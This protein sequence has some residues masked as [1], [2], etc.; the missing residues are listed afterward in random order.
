MGGL[1]LPENLQIERRS[2]MCQTLL[3]RNLNFMFPGPTLGDADQLW[4]RAREFVI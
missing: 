1:F 2:V 3:L 4:M